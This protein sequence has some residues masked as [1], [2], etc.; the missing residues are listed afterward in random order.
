MRANTTSKRRNCSRRMTIESLETRRLMAFDP[1]GLEQ[2]ALEH[3]NR[4]RMDPAA[5]LDVLFTSQPQPL[6]AADPVVKNAIEYFQV[7]GIALQE[8]W[9]QLRPAPPLAWNEHLLNAARVHSQAMIDA[10]QLSH[11]LPGEAP[12]GERIAASGYGSYQAV[13][14]NA[15][16][17]AESDLHAHAA[18]A[19][20]WGSTATGIQDGHGHRTNLMNP[21]YTEIGIGILSQDDSD[22][23]VGPLVVTQDFGRRWAAEPV[24]LGVVFQDDDG[25]GRYDAGEGL[26]DV[27]VAMQ[28]ESG[29]VLFTQTMSAGG[30][31]LKI[32][33]GA[34]TVTAF[35]SDS[36][37]P[38]VVD[39]VIVAGENVKVD[40]ALDPN[41]SQPPATPLSGQNPEDR[42]DVNGDG[43]ITALDALIVIN[44]V[45]ANGPHRL[46]EEAGPDHYGGMWLDVNG[47]GSVTAADS[48]IVI[49]RLNAWGPHRALPESVGDPQQL[50]VNGDWTITRA[51][52]EFVLAHM[53]QE[54]DT[55]PTCDV[56]SD[57][58]V[59]PLDALVI[60]NHVSARAD[61]TTGG[62]TAAQV[63][64]ASATGV[65]SGGFADEEVNDSALLD[66]LNDGNDL[67]F[68]GLIELVA[69]AP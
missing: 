62:V 15:F 25:N 27:Q 32:P 57:G 5:E 61:A 23:E 20:D 8:Q 18:F 40:F 38:L 2:E 24:V 51:D 26:A 17:N 43:L 47:D 31:Q 59:T 66:L 29:E 63:E 45:N 64:T 6:V 37:A 68:G 48:L 54:V 4:M 22:A 53:Y 3:I 10:D 19:I 13:A 39:Q 50:D 7:D 35:P 16:A 52:V 14:E 42:C 28:N 67:L 69:A 12:L 44:H 36:Q 60:L 30:Y 46:A 34:Y 55:C 49:N 11:Q 9:A 58:L 41:A 1:T 65:L 56:N 33:A 21:T